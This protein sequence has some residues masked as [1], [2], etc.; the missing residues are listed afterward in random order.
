MR[1]GIALLAMTALLA[2]AQPAVAG[3]LSL[4]GVAGPYTVRVTSLKELRFKRAF[5][6]TVHQQFD[7]SCGSAAVATL[8]TYHYGLG[9]SERHVFQY[10]YEHG[11]RDKIRAVGFSMLD[12]KR[13][14]QASGFGADG[15]EASVEQI[16]AAGV[17]AIVLLQDQGYNH[18]VVVKGVHGGKVLVGD[19]ALGIRI[20]SRKDFEDR[21]P[22]RIAFVITSKARFATFNA[23]A[24][25]N[26]RPDMP[27]E[28]AIGRES[29]AAITVLRLSG[30]DF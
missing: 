15:F 9:V 30:R 24:D 26:F 12:M 14:L 7:F 20:L 5:A 2:G 6:R 8:L 22:S 13:Y 27:L 18:F 17:P 10:M 16:G 4:A 21:W 3:E 29:L 19:P 28:A 23:A 11:D 1:G 25:W